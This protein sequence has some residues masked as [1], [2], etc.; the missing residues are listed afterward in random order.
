MNLFCALNSH[1]IQHEGACKVHPNGHIS[2]LREGASH[3][4]DT[5]II[6][7][8]N[9]KLRTISTITAAMHAQPSYMYHQNYQETAASSVPSQQAAHLLQH[10]QHG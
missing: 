6:T 8:T 5:G 7:S 9:A 3:N 2:E 4:A 10:T 1:K